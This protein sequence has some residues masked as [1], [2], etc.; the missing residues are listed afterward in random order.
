MPPVAFAGFSP[1]LDVSDTL[2]RSSRYDGLLSMR[3][4][5]QLGPK[6]SRGPEPLRGLANLTTDAT[7]ALFPRSI[8][9]VA[10]RE[11]LM[12]DS[13]ALHDALQRAGVPTE[14]HV[15]DGQIHALSWV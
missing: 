11:A 5:R 2:P 6:Y 12:V 9:F 3:K 1:L 10:D 15:Y 4:I 14:V 13:L 7:A 8:M